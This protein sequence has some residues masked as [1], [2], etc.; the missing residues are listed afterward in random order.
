MWWLG[1]ACQSVIGCDTLAA[2]CLRG[3]YDAVLLGSHGD[4][5]CFAG[6][7]GAGGFATWFGFAGALLD[8]LRP[9]V[10]YDL[11]APVEFVVTSLQVDGDR[12]FA[13]VAA[14]RPMGAPIDMETTPMVLRDGL[15]LDTIDGPRIEA[16][17][18]QS[19][20]RW[21]VVEFV[22]GATDVWWWAY[23]CKHYGGL[24][25]EWGC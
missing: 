3:F 11:G 16:F 10:E 13:R 24:L 12:A 7:G 8:T 4:D 14:Q 17:F 6:V 1:R 9:L 15:P 19:P 22:I 23:D 20:A 25:S 2:C 5:L 18:Y 21:E